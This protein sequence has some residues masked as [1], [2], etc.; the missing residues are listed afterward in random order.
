MNDNEISTALAKAIG[1]P[2]VIENSGEVL[3]SVNHGWGRVFDYR[4]PDVSWP[5]AK[6]FSMFP[7]PSYFSEKWLVRYESQDPRIGEVLTYADT[8]EKAVAMAVIARFK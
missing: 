8:P 3:V 6:R 4:A 7:E 2:Q 5:I 1:W